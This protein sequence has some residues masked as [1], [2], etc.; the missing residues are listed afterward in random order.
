LY[1]FLSCRT[2]S[3]TCV[4]GSTCTVL[5]PCNFFVRFAPAYSHEFIDYSQCIPGAAT[6]SVVSSSPPPS[7]TSDPNPTV[8]PTSP[9]T[10]SSGPA[11]TGSQIRAV[12]DPVYHFYLQDY[13]MRSRINTCCSFLLLI[14]PA[15]GQPVL[16]PESSS[17]Y[18]NIGGGTIS[19]TGSTPLY[20][21]VQTGA[22]TSYKPLTFNSTATTT[23][24][25][26][27]GDTIITSNPR[28]LNFLA[29]A[30]SNANYYTVY[31]Q[32]G[33]DQPAG[34]SCSMQSLHLPCLC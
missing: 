21:N 10:T 9:T 19:L 8:L 20:L 13:G 16:G 26:L 23:D 1:L 11:P 14:H 30:T 25:V 34:E 18:F 2:G 7:T 15:G 27:E 33:N 12:N 24:W 31:L 32:Y 4:S 3:T 29:C 17:G 6:T 28:E 22:T 5:N